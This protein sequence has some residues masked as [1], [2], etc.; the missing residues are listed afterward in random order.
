[1]T[2]KLKPFTLVILP[3]LCFI[4]SY[5][6][7]QKGAF[8]LSGK[9]DLSFLFS[10]T[11]IERDSIATNKLKDNQFGFNVGV[12]YFVADNFAVAVSGA[13]SYT[14]DRFEATNYSPATTETITTTL[15]IVP[16]LIYYF[17]LEGKLKPSLSIGAGYVWL[18]QR[19][20]KF[21]GN[22]NQVYSLAGPSVNGAAGIS[23]FITPSVAFELGLQYSHN[24]LN[25]KLNT[26][27]M[28]KQNTLA[29]TFGVSIFF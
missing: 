18:K 28:Q 1:M 3:L 19:D 15:A 7:T 11:T 29:G 2:K 14:F 5:S 13:Y 10:N 20:S 4:Q 25:D 12:G 23:Y 26:R 24:K 9:S 21:T 17:P 8:I 27:V 16:Q 22:N 6:Q